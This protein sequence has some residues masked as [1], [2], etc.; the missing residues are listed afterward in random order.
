MMGRKALSAARRLLAFQAYSWYNACRTHLRADASVRGRICART[1]PCADASVRLASGEDVN[2]ARPVLM[3][4]QARCQ[5]RVQAERRAMATKRSWILVIPLLTVLLII[6]FWR[7]ATMQGVVITNDIAISDIANQYHPVRHFLGRELHAGR[8][9]LWLPEI[10][11]G[12]PIQAEGQMGAFYPPN[13]LFFGLLPSRVAQNLSILWPFFVAAFATYALARQLGAAIWPSLVAAVA[14]AL[15]GF[16]IVHVKHMSIVHVA[17]WLPLTWLFIEL[18]LE[19]DRRYLLAVG[20]VWAIQWLAGMPQM[21]YY[22]V[23][24]GVVY[25]IGRAIQTKQLKRTGLL[26][27][28]A[29]A[30][31]F[32]L[33][34]VQIWPT[35]E[36]AGLS[37]RAGGVDFEFASAFDY[38]IESLWTWLYPYA[39]G[40]PGL[41]NYQIRGLFWEDYAYIGLLPLVAGLAGGLW[42][43][44]K[45]GPA[46]LLLLLAGATFVIALG[47]NTPIFRLAYAWLPG[48]NYFRFPQRL[49]VVTTLCLALMAALCLTWL[50]GWLVSSR[51]WKALE[52]RAPHLVSVGTA[53]V[54]LI[55]LSLVVADLYFYHIRQNAIVDAQTWYDP[56]QTAQRIHHDAGSSG[57]S[58][59]AGLYRVFTVGA[60]TRFL[61]AYREAGGWEGDLTP[62]V[63][64]REFLQPSLNILYDI[65]SADGY[66]NLTPG[67]LTLVWGNEK[68][69]GF[70]EQLIVLSDDRLRPRQGFGKLLNLYNVRYLITPIP[71]DGDG[72][73]L[74][75][76][77][78]LQV[79]L[80]R[81]HNVLP[82]AYAVP[83]YTL[84]DNVPAALERMISPAFDPEKEVMLFRSPAERTLP[85]G[86]DGFVSHVEM[87]SY[88][89]LYVLVEVETNQPGFLVLSDLYYPGWEATVDGQPVPIY[90]ANVSVRAV[91]LDGGWHQ[92]EFRLKPKPLRYGA[93]ISGL[94]LLVLA[95]A[96][97]LS[98][99]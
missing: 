9:P 59:D 38:Q 97:K 82:R 64:Q 85:P 91:P 23:G 87:V 20:V 57:S 12:Y 74:L 13:L 72:F 65:P 14:Y 18:G 30:L 44:R 58:A 88:E 3:G 45:R 70:V 48:M 95:V 83:G 40:D 35:M 42:L 1:H 90:Q 36:L 92:V 61:E 94:S 51:G 6:P 81:N 33:A 86:S 73:E 41:A 68:R 26:L 10:Y 49:Q 11:M 93:L 76:V 43:A 22:S 28:L 52:I 54:G 96:W 89:P 7:V 78:G 69:P 4:G 8:L 2:A 5:A 31:S 46:R 27:A 37:E 75:G 63:A 79:Y 19:R 99:A 56:P 66:V 50:Q 21:A 67:H 60:V 32:G 25:Y 53:L 55:L 15:G 24:V 80:Y 47:T 98:K 29:L 17:C 39:N 71:F 34:A 77:Y 62:Y 84:A 16:Y